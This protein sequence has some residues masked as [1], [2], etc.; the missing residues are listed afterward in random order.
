MYG[1]QRLRVT[2]IQAPKDDRKIFIDSTS[3]SL[4][5]YP[6]IHGADP[7]WFM[8]QEDSL[9]TRRRSRLRHSTACEDALIAYSGEDK[10][11]PRNS[12]LQI[13]RKRSAHEIESD[14]DPRGHPFADDS[15]LEDFGYDNVFDTLDSVSFIE[16]S[17][18]DAPMQLLEDDSHAEHPATDTSNQVPR[19]DSCAENL[20]TVELDHVCGDDDYADTL[21]EVLEDYNFAEHPATDTFHDE[22][23]ARW[24]PI[25]CSELGSKRIRLVKIIPGPLGGKIECQVSLC[26]LDEAPSYTAVSYTWGSPLGFR[27]ILIGGR[28]HSVAKN[29][30]RFLDQARRLRDL[31]P[32]TGWLWIDALSIDQSS[33]QE[34]LDQVGIISSIFSNA[35]RVIVWLGPS[36]ADSDDALAALHANSTKR[37]RRDPRA[38]PGPVWSAL[39]SLCERPYWRRLWVYQ[40]LRSALCAELMCGAKFFPLGDFQDYMFETATRRLEEKLEVLRKSSA[41]MMLGLT[42]DP[43]GASLWSLIHETSHLRCVD[44]RD[45]AYAILKIA[46]TGSHKIEADYTITVPVLLNQILENMHDTAPPAS[47]DEVAEQCME[48]ERLFGEPLN[49]MFVTEDALGFSRYMNPIRQLAKQKGSPDLKLQWLLSAWCFFYSHKYIQQLVF[50]PQTSA[51][52]VA[53]T[54]PHYPGL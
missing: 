45:K 39:H 49:S 23:I 2:M 11:S 41:G 51:Q 43:A 37:Q 30:W 33:A 27:E 20:A 26:F 42:A 54:R 24:P 34:K 50:P 3:A 7:D 46:Q 10:P 40:E 22:H 52:S 4:S 14:T 13:P 15:D 1:K 44:P 18:T 6:I 47:L 17:A 25:T 38:S 12:Y 28:P 16:Y 8:R 36:Y 32:L 29:L 5:E 53:A 48:L 21:D 31:S 19:D 35:E 9:A